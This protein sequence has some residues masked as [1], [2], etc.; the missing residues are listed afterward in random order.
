MAFKPRELTRLQQPATLTD[1]RSLPTPA[2]HDGGSSDPFKPGTGFYSTG[3]HRVFTPLSPDDFF[4]VIELKETAQGSFRVYTKVVDQSCLTWLCFTSSF[5]AQ[6][7]S[8]PRLILLHGGGH[9]GASWACLTSQLTQLCDCQVVAFDARGHGATVVKGDE[10]GR[11]TMAKLNATL[12]CHL[13]WH[14][15]IIGHAMRGPAIAVG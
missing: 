14:R 11:H 9:S 15:S 6:G 12:P 8:G 7:Q 5:V 2:R 10:H 1:A 4:D 3:A 13:H